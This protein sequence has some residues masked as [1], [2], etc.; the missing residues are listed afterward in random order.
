MKSLLYLALVPFIGLSCAIHGTSI[1]HSTLSDIQ[2]VKIRVFEKPKDYANMLRARNL[3]DKAINFVLALGNAAGKV[4]TKVAEY[5]EATAKN[6]SQL[7]TGAEDAIA[8]AMAAQETSIAT[9]ATKKPALLE[10]IDE[11]EPLLKGRGEERKEVSRSQVTSADRVKA[12][13][14]YL[15]LAVDLVKNLKEESSAF[16]SLVKTITRKIFTIAHFPEVPK[17]STVTFKDKAQDPAQ[18][19]VVILERKTEIPLW[20]GLVDKNRN[21]S[22]IAKKQRDGSTI[23]LLAAKGQERAALTGLEEETKAPE[24]KKEPTKPLEKPIKPEEP[25]K[26]EVAEKTATEQTKGAVE[27]ETKATTEKQTTAAET[28]KKAADDTQKL[29]E[30]LAKKTT[31]GA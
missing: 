15:P 16:G 12:A 26:K 17:G 5:E 25:S 7:K 29:T 28:T 18:T 21:Y 4:L 10:R 8:A 3:S 27:K 6:R 9:Q 30:E 2:T 13:S 1:T 14:T 19:F 20:L 22:F 11:D 31:P 24:V 23:G